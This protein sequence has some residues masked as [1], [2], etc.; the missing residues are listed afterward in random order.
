MRSGASAWYPGEL[1]ATIWWRQEYQSSGK[2]WR[3]NTTGPCPFSAICILMPF[4]STVLCSI[5]SIT[6][7]SLVTNAGEKIEVCLE[8]NLIVILIS[9]QCRVRLYK[10]HIHIHILYKFQTHVLNS[11][12]ISLRD[13][14][15][16]GYDLGMH[17]GD[18]K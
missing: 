5:P 15:N 1:R 12:F 7:F 17:L 2:P 3:N 8:E 6:L 11:P 10:I 14:V 18:R 13:P 4:T 9:T 16:I